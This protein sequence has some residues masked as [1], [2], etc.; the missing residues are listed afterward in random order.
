MPST[1]T[2]IGGN[3]TAIQAAVLA[4]PGFPTSGITTTSNDVV[5][6]AVVVRVPTTL[7]AP[8]EAELDTACGLAAAQG[9]FQRAD[10][11][12]VEPPSGGSYSHP[13]HTGDVTSVGDGAQTIAAGAVVFSKIQSV[14]AGTVLGRST[15]GTGDVE[16]LTLGAN[17]TLVAGVLNS[18]PGVGGAANVG[19]ATIDFGAFPG[20][21]DT[22]V[23]VTG[24][25][26]IVA[27]SVVMVAIRPVAT[28]EHSADEHWVEELDVFAGN[29]VAGTGFT[30]YAKTRNRRLYGSFTVAWSWA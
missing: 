15:I 20:K 12:W 3:Q 7:T 21:S 30:I 4:I 10:G 19:T 5:G 11:E 8:Q 13:N 23:A 2:I 18:L 29:I 17:M 28:A 25:T 24:Q 6:T 14:S 27:G 22:S 26:S 9:L 1:R 16:S